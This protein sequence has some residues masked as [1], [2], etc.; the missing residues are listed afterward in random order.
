VWGRRV[1]VLQSAFISSTLRQDE[2]AKQGKGNQMH[3]SADFQYP[4]AWKLPGG[5]QG[6]TWLT[7]P[8][9]YTLKNLLRTG[10]ET[11]ATIK[12]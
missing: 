9:K 7:K 5:Q 2:T 1:I 8:T 4:F 11:K 12:L 10:T 3:M 6:S